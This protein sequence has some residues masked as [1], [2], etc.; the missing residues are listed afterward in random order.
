MT[1]VQFRDVGGDEAGLRLDR[2]FRLH[3]PDLGHAAFVRSIVLYRDESV[4]VVNKPPGLAVQGGTGT[5]RHLDAMVDA[6]RFGN[7]EAPRLVHRL[8][9]DTSGVLLLG[10]TRAA[11]AA[12]AKAFRRRTA[13][14]IYW[15][16]TVGTPRIPAGK[17]DL[18]LAKHF[19]AGGERV[20]VDRQAG[21]Q[22]VTWYRVIETAASRF[23]WIALWPR[24]GRTHQLRVHCLSLGCP[25]LGDAKYGGAEAMVGGEEIPQQLHLHARE[26]VLPHP[27]S[28]DAL[29]ARA[30]LPTH[31]L[32]TWKLFGFDP[33]ATAD[34][35]AEFE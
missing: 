28:A 27:A 23:A 34:P 16:V 11:T 10:R 20:E 4:V 25:I 35:F 30:P 29:V 15:A 17:I 8:D 31:M 1:G 19:G 13:R 14:K 2:W 7:D 21:R 26:I 6:L 3:F 9:R 22:A 5:M 12:L 32:T 18:P 24:T 33:D